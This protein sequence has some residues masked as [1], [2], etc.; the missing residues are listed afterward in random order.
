MLGG[1]NVAAMDTNKTTG[2]ERLKKYFDQPFV[3]DLMAARAAKIDK[4]ADEIEKKKGGPKEQKAKARRARWRKKYNAREDVKARRNAY[5][6]RPEVKAKR[7]A[8]NA[9]PDVK[10]HR[11]RLRD[12]KALV[13]RRARD[14]VSGKA[15]ES[16][17]G[18]EKAA[19]KT[20]IPLEMR[21][22]LRGQ[23]GG[24]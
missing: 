18:R 6:Q 22:F 3:K 24:F 19:R 4:M 5:N 7:D 21:E 9:D 11:Q 23:L 2:A 12:A 17:G 15:P 20:E 16:E 1:G 10:A 13:S 8:Y 14:G